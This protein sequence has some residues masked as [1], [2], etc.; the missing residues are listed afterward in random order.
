MLS[1]LS[2][3]CHTLAKEGQLKMITQLEIQIDN[4]V[5]QLYGIT[6]TE[7]KEVK[8]TLTIIAEEDSDDGSYDSVRED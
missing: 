8:D 3:Q 1:Q 2:R 4:E 5:A 6:G 7:L